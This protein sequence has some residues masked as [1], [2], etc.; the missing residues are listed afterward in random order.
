MGSIRSG[1]VMTERSIVHSQLKFHKLVQK[2]LASINP[3]FRVSAQRVRV[4]AIQNKIVTVEIHF[5]EIDKKAHV[6]KCPVCHGKLK[7][8]RNK[9]IF[10]GSVTLAKECT[11]C[12]YWVG[13]KLH[14]PTMYV[15]TLSPE[16]SKV[17]DAGKKPAPKKSLR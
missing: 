17:K 8:V 15:F 11:Q 12:T 9:T 4:L 6:I 13:L 14:I 3:A 5:K 1:K 2:Q 10:G 16:F 7:M